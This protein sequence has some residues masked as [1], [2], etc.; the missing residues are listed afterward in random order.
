MLR[1][2][3]IYAKT[4]HGYSEGVKHDW[5]EVFYPNTNLEQVSWLKF[6]VLN[7][8]NLVKYGDGIW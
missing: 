4:V 5:I 1:V 2:N 3:N 7:K 8:D 6:D